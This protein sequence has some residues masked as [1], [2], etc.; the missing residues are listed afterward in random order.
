MNQNLPV[1]LL[2]G[3]ILLPHQEVKIELNN[4]ISKEITSLASK[5]YNRHVLVITPKNQ[6]EETPEV[7]DLPEVGVIA[8]IKSRIELPNGNVRVTL[9]GIDRVKILE[10]N[11]NNYNNDILEAV[12][13]KIELPELDEVEKKA[14]IRKLNELIMDYVS[15]S[16]HVSN[17]IINNIKTIDSLYRLTDTICSFM[18]LSFN[19]KVE[20]LEEINALYRAKN[21]LKDIKVEIEV[22]K[23][24]EK[25]DEELENSL[26]ESQKEYILKEKVRILERELGQ[27]TTTDINNYL[28]KLNS[29]NLSKTTYNKIN[30]E[31]KKLNYTSELS[32]ENAMI[33]NYLDW[34]LNLPWGFI[35]DENNDIE[36]IKSKLD[37]KHYGL[38]D[39]KER[40]L[41]YVALKN[42][43]SDIKSPIICLVGPP[44]VGKTSIAKNIANSLNRKFYKISVGGLNDS[45]E[46]IGHRRTYMGSNPGKIIQGLKKC[47]S[48]NPVF[49]IDE[50]DKITSNYKDD[51][52]SVLL[53][54]LDREQNNEFIDNYIEEPFDLSKVFFILT[55]NT[56]DTIPEALKDRLEIINLTSYTNYEKIDIAKKYLIPRILD[57]NKIESKIISISD[58]MLEYLIEAYT[59]EAGVRELNRVLEKVIRKLVLLG[60]IND[61]TKISKVRLKEYLGIPKYIKLENKKHEYTGRVNAVGVTSNGG[62]VMPIESCVFEGKSNFKITGMLGKVMEEST[63]VALSYIKANVKK[64]SIE[65]FF[66]NIKDIHIHFLEGALKKDGPSAG[67]AIT[68]SIL[69][70]ILNKNISNDIAFTGEISLN[71]EI[72]KVGGI[73]EKIIGAYN[74]DIKTIYIPYT[75]ELDLEEIPEN[76][77]E[78]IN[79]ILVKNYDEIFNEIF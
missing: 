43:N 15:S 21:L 1:M 18:P 26:E 79:I 65:D 24:D 28:D 69:S 66:F 52:T 19:K 56:L 58:E 16:K 12:V 61:R 23:L 5:E 6:I 76:I 31:I 20:Y 47:G 7:N 48:I 70:L 36:N 34:I 10:F 41:E 9:R 57:D 51:P 55:A 54:I 68:T 74:N 59:N 30:N 25:L 62:I 73:K 29:L 22:L 33:R 60:K 32:P 45:S 3:L 75:N 40:I 8:K 14:T 72:L 63:N 4:N 71:G 37:S 35:D 2:K 27:D 42:N 13:T 11:N 44:G 17:S 50:I 53:D 67:V 64:F 38:K 46:L 77:K 78:K 49:L 39:I